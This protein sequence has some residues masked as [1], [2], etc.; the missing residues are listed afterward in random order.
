VVVYV[1][2]SVGVI[3]LDFVSGVCI[4]ISIHVV[5][6]VGVVYDDAVVVVVVVV[7]IIIAVVDGVSACVVIFVV[8]V[9]SWLC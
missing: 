9:F 8:C 7:A 2:G 1:V 3:V 5:V 4:N 6:D